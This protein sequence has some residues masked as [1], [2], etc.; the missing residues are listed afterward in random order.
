MFDMANGTKNVL[1]DYIIDIRDKPARRDL[2]MTLFG[3]FFVN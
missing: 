2:A 1:F 3:G